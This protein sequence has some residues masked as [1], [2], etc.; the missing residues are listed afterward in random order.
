MFAYGLQEG[1]EKIK[2]KII[3]AEEKVE[4]KKKEKTELGKS[5]FTSWF[6]KKEYDCPEIT[7]PESISLSLEDEESENE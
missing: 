2:E 5:Y 4:E 7:I 3:A 1:F 6:D